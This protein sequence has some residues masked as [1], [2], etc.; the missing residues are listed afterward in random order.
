MD[1]EQA[2]LLFDGSPTRQRGAACNRQVH[3]SAL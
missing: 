3:P 1:D 2:L